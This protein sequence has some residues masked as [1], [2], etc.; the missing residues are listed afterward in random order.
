MYK[1]IQRCDYALQ[2]KI[3]EVHELG[4]NETTVDE[5]GVDEPG[6]DQKWAGLI[7]MCNAG[8]AGCWESG[9]D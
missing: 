5:T 8:T 2:N 3:E 6:I 7:P 4:L 1:C 9:Q